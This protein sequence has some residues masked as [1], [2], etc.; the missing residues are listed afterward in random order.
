MSAAS[1]DEEEVDIQTIYAIRTNAK[2]Q[3]TRQA[4]NLKAMISG[5]ARSDDVN[6]ALAVLKVACSEVRRVNA[7]YKKALEK[8]RGARTDKSKEQE[9]VEWEAEINALYEE[10]RQAA[11]EHEDGEKDED[12]AVPRAKK[13]RLELELARQQAK[14]EEQRKLDDIRKQ[15]QREQEDLTLQI[16]YHRQL[17]GLKPTGESSFQPKFFSTIMD[18]DEEKR[19]R[20]P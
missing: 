2:R 9:A 19:P 20:G 11:E 17:E 14:L 8:E 10:C 7:Q 15:S 1:D 18:P 13:R 12:D 4:N 3:H 6:V 16:K 5:G